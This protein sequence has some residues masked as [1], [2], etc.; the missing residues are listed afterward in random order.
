VG[1]AKHQ[2]KA[3]GTRT[4][5][6]PRPGRTPYQDRRKG[7]IYRRKPKKITMAKKPK[8]WKTTFFGIA[9]VI[10]GVAL[11]LKGN[12]IEGVTAITAGL[13]LSAAKDFDATN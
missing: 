5:Q 6:Q 2:D 3:A 4:T 9:S 11:I 7:T 12:L 1:I 13:G 10:S 8:N